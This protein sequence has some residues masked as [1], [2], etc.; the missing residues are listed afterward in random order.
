MKFVTNGMHFAG[1]GGADL[2]RE[3]DGHSMSVEGI[4]GESFW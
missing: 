4:G 3:D 1:V 2:Y